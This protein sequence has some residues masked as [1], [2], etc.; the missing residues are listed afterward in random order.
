MGGVVL[1]AVTESDVPFVL[2]LN[3]RNVARLSPLDA[4]RLAQLRGWADR[5][6]V[7]LLD[8]Q[9]AGFVVTV[10]PGTDYDSANYRWFVD[11]FGD[12]FYY[13]D[14]IV[15]DDR[16]RRSGIG[17]AVY[18]E[19]ERHATPYSRMALEVDVEP[20]NEASLAF[21]RDRG[22]QPVGRLAG[23][24]KA[25]ALMVLELAD[26]PTDTPTGAPTGRAPA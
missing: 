4:G 1:R 6:D 19:L 17:R 21:H 23:G 20:P 9:P 8:G 15:V 10:G 3:A 18:D 2:D 22:Y 14:R 13:L 26:G 11:R 12:S 5:T 25:A 24:G 7:V 16:F